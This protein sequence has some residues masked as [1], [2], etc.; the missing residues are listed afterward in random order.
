MDQR[1]FAIVLCAYLIGSIP[2]SQL[3][4]HWRA[5]LNLREVG[6]GN[7]GSRNVWH[8]VGPRWG[9]LAAL[10]DGL[11]GYVVCRAASVLVPPLGVLLAGIAVLL[12]HQFP[13][14]LRGR[15]G[16][17][18]ATSL[19]VL[20]ALSPLSSMTGLAVLG[21]AYLV[22]RDFNPSL[23]LAIIAIIVLPV[24]FHQPLWISAYALSLALLAALKK[25]LDLAHEERVWRDHPWQGSATPGWQPPASEETSPGELCP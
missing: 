18:L 4:A 13:I 17:G 11:K 20:L 9:I 2:F 16:K 21:L 1:S 8:L 6:E 5:G 19:G 3:I 24:V 14:Y 25:R 10:L 22:C 7:V 12:G 15:G 23:V